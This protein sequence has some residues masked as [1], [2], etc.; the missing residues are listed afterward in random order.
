LQA[1]YRYAIEWSDLGSQGNTLFVE[2]FPPIYKTVSYS[3]PLC[4]VGKLEGSAKRANLLQ[5]YPENVVVDQKSGKPTPSDTKVDICVT[6]AGTSTDGLQHAGASKSFSTQTPDEHYLT[7]PFCVLCRTKHRLFI[8][9][10]LSGPWLHWEDVTGG[11]VPAD[12]LRQPSDVQLG[13]SGHYL[14]FA[15]QERAQEF[16]NFTDAILFATSAG[17]T[18]TSTSGSTSV[19][20]TNTPRTVQAFDQFGNP[21]ILQIL[22]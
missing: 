6:A 8:N 11:P 14:F 22:P 17:P 5:A 13:S 19:Q 12:R 20:A 15:S 18:A 3:Q 21:I 16:V 9:P 4:L 2:S 10:N 7:L 1:L